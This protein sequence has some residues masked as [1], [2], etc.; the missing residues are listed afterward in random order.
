MSLKRVEW[1]PAFGNPGDMGTQNPAIQSKKRVR[2][3]SILPV[4]G[5]EHTLEIGFEPHF[6]KPERDIWLFV[7]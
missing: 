2:T 6:L 1:A 5:I 3:A 4:R 7:T